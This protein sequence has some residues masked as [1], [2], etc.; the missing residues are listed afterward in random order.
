MPTRTSLGY[1]ARAVVS[2]FVCG[3]MLWCACSTWTTAYEGYCIEAYWHSPATPYT[4]RVTG[5][6][7]WGNGRRERIPTVTITFA[8]G[9]TA[10][11]NSSRRARYSPGDPVNVLESCDEVR[12]V[13]Q[14]VVLS[15]H[16][17]KIYEIDDPYL[18][19]IDDALYGVL[20]LLIALASPLVGFAPIIALARGHGA[21]GGSPEA[22]G[23]ASE[24]GAASAGVLRPP[25]LRALFEAAYTPTAG[26]AVA[27]Y[28]MERGQ[29]G[30]YWKLCILGAALLVVIFAVAAWAMKFPALALAGVCVSS[31]TL[32][33]VRLQEWQLGAAVAKS[34]PTEVRC[35]FAEEGL[36]VF[37]GGSQVL[38]RWERV[39]KASIDD[40]GVLLSTG[41]GTKCFIPS[42]GFAGGHFPREAL[43]SFLSGKLRNP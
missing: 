25:P 21:H 43:K 5:F 18:L 24:A 12:L 10:E 38:Y 40:R 33:A 16:A 37:G 41:G 39:G 42:R 26:D 32:G 9:K 7:I 6:P 8:D 14:G 15:R 22:E 3:F 34:R 35:Y 23:N 11:F 4:A 19:W 36:E 17:G 27:A 28:R 30:D 1:A 20:L 13:I 29:S 31:A 2:I